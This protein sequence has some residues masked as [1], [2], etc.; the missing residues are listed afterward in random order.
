MS[1]TSSYWGNES[2]KGSTFKA[3]GTIIN[4]PLIVGIFNNISMGGFTDNYGDAGKSL[5][6]GVVQNTTEGSPSS[7]CLQITTP[8]FW[9]FKWT[10]A[11]GA[12]S[13]SV[14]AKQTGTTTPTT[15]PSLIVKSN[16]SIGLSAD[17]SGSAANSQGWVTIGPVSFTATGAGVTW[18]ELHNNAFMMETP[19]YFDHIVAT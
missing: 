18:V 9:R 5:Q 13:I 11:A 17:I 6:S 19:A 4:N 10:V 8:G 16:S 3:K 2:G 14:S 1:A 7:P 12:R 15:R